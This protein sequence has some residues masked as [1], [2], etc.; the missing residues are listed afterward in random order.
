MWL[1][2]IFIKEISAALFVAA[3]VDKTT[4]ATNKSSSLSLCGWKWG[5]FWSEGSV[6]D[7]SWCEWWQTSRCYIFLVVLLVSIYSRL[8][9]SRCVQPVLFSQFL[10]VNWFMLL[11]TS[12]WRYLRR[13]V[14]T[15]WHRQVQGVRP[16]DPELSLLTFVLRHW[17]CVHVCINKGNY[18]KVSCLGEHNRQELHPLELTSKVTREFA[19]NGIPKAVVPKLFCPRN[20]ARLFQVDKEPPPELPSKYKHFFHSYCRY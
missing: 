4:D 19:Y 1:D 20:T 14:Q 12:A 6:L 7:I 2:M 11:R 17:N 16:F 5:G 9:I 18:R 10:E 8:L 3:E 13:C 15:Y